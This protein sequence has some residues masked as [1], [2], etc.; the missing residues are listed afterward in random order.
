MIWGILK[1]NYS[2]NISIE[3][4]ITYNMFLH[5]HIHEKEHFVNRQTTQLVLVEHSRKITIAFDNRNYDHTLL[6]GFRIVSLS[7]AS[8]SSSWSSCNNFDPDDVFLL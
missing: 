3:I 1:A 5:N 2:K 6:N 7:S 4:L 8:S